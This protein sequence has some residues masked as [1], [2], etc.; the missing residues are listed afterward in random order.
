MISPPTKHEELSRRSRALTGPPNQ[1]CVFPPWSSKASHFQGSVED[2]IIQGPPSWEEVFSSL[3]EKAKQDLPWGLE[4]RRPR[5]RASSGQRVFSQNTGWAGPAAFKYF[6]CVLCFLLCFVLGTL[7]TIVVFCGYVSFWE[8][9]GKVCFRLGFRHSGLWAVAICTPCLW[10]PLGSSFWCFQRTA[11]TQSDT[12]AHYLAPTVYIA[13]C[14]ALRQDG[15][16]P[17][18]KHLPGSGILFTLAHMSPAIL[19]SIV[20]N[21]DSKMQIW[22]A[23]LLFKNPH[24]ENND[25]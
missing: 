19:W 4:G 12:Y 20:H 3:P 22:Q 17:Q 10:L 5:W 25:V 21:W 15:K 23:A 14:W 9:E 11:V 16:W 7:E 13:L 24:W 2:R 6:S 1:R 8:F 18:G